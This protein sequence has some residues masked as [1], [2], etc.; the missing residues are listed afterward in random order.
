MSAAFSLNQNERIVVVSGAA[1]GLG[2]AIAD[3]FADHGA[4]VLAA[5]RSLDKPLPGRLD[6]GSGRVQDVYVDVSDE[7]LIRSLTELIESSDLTVDVLINN[8]GIMYKAPIEDIDLRIR[9]ED[10]PDF[11]AL[12]A[13]GEVTRTPLRDATT[14]ANAP[15]IVLCFGLATMHAVGF[16]M[17]LAY[18]PNF[19]SATHGYAMS[20][21]LLA[22]MVALLV[23][24]AVIP[25]TT[26]LS[27][28]IGRRPVMAAAACIGYLVCAYPVF[29]LMGS[30]NTLNIVIS[31]V[32]ISV[33][34]G[35]FVGTLF[36]AMI[37]LFCTRVRYT[38]FSIGY[39][40]A[41]ALFGGTAP[42]IAAWLVA[43]TGAA[44]APAFYIMAAAVVSS[45]AVGFAPETARLPLRKE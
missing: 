6:L 29:W 2:R 40:V 44:T 21:A 41:I 30:S 3:A 26:M 34:F 22:T 5:D 36:S 12:V 32:I 13:P 18:I 45:I 9:V 38:S 17:V 31:Q 23:A 28:R 42:F 16:Y 19:L 11:R 24:I 27:D 39:N 33:L 35:T 8:A 4:F 10:T 43:A 20:N 7:Y 25:L 37:E 14:R 15:R 1:R